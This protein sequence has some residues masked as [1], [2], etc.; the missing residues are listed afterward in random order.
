MIE[1]VGE[2]TSTDRPMTLRMM[3][4]EVLSCLV[5]RIRRVRHPFLERGSWFLLHDNAKPHTAVAIK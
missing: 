1:T 5:Q 3:K 2:L 4:E